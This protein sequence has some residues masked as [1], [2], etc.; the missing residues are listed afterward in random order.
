M[1]LFSGLAVATIT[2]FSRGEIDFESYQKYLLFLKS[3]GIK[4][5][6]INGSTGEPHSLSLKERLTLLE[7]ARN[8]LPDCHIIAGICSNNTYKAIEE[9]EYA[10]SLK[11]DSLLVI[12]PFCS[13]CTDKGLYQHFKEIKDHSSLD[14]IAYNVPSRT[15]VSLAPRNIEILA[16]ERI[17]Q[18]IK[19]SD[20]NIVNTALFSRF[21]DIFSGDDGSIAYTKPFNQKGAISVLANV[22][23]EA[24][25]A[26]LSLPLK[27]AVSLQ[28]SLSPLISSL[29]AEVNPVLIKHL[30]TKLN[31]IKE[32]LRLPLTEGKPENKRI[33]IEEALKAGVPNLSADV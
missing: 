3:N 2:P 20:T 15:G 17:I 9:S 6:A 7:F 29:F 10:A 33:L 16:K 1:S 21:T 12:T 24:V 13:K 22:Y 8:T 32:E 23:P 27:D 25:Q 26:L 5:F 18:G 14:I 31:L 28:H 19:Q 11:V 4:N 30:L